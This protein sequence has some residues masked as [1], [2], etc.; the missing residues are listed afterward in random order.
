MQQIEMSELHKTFQEVV[1]VVRRLNIRYLWIDT[2]CIIQDDPRDWMQESAKICQV[3]R[4][5][6]ICIAASAAA[7]C[8]A[9]LIQPFVSSVQGTYR[10]SDDAKFSIRISG[11]HSR[12]GSAPLEDRAWTLQEDLL[13]RRVLYFAKRQLL[14]HCKAIAASEDGLLDGL[15]CEESSLLK[16]RRNVVKLD[17]EHRVEAYDCWRRL[18][19]MYSRRKI[20]FEE[21]RLLA[22]AGITVHFRDLLED[23]PISGLWRNDFVA[24]LLWVPTYNSIRSPVP[25]IPSWSWLSI[26]GGINYDELWLAIGDKG[27]DYYVDPS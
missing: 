16:M 4:D 21:D 26:K 6:Y 18:A 11:M 10:R 22:L 5:A 23:E 17:G 8:T 7:D 15:E 1:Q 3:Y 19:E 14:W 24:G 13:A 25:G 9:G 12:Q 2:L 27:N 20:T